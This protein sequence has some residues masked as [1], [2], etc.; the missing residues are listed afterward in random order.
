MPELLDFGKNSVFI[1]SC[2]G[3][4]FGVLSAMIIT[5]LHKRKQARKALAEISEKQKLE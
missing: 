4:T 1:W 3:V 5:S 2:Y